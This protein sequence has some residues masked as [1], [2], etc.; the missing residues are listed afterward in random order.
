MASWRDETPERLVEYRRRRVVP[1]WVAVLIVALPIVLSVVLYFVR[2]GAHADAAT[3]K[4][5]I[6][7]NIEHN[8]A[9]LVGGFLL[10]LAVALGAFSIYLAY[11]DGRHWQWF[12]AGGIIASA[13]SHF[14]A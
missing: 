8:P 2:G 9:D 12:F 14:F 13:A 5:H 6:E 7:T 11:Y 3:F 10:G 1:V 4:G